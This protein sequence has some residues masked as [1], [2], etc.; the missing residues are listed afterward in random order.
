MAR[1]EDAPRDDRSSKNEGTNDRERERRS[2]ESWTRRARPGWARTAWFYQ[3]APLRAHLLFAPTLNHVFKG[4]GAKLREA[5]SD[6]GGLDPAGSA[7]AAAELVEAV[8]H[9][10]T[11][12]EMAPYA[13]ELWH[14]VALVDADLKHSGSPFLCGTQTN[15]LLILKLLD[16]SNLA[17]LN[18]L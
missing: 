6:P 14:R 17:R 16:A 18:S 5:L 7:D 1:F 3:L 8:E 12:A 10:H 9:P 4:D 2:G 11:A 13:S 15:A